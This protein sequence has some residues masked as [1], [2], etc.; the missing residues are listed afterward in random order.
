MLRILSII[1]KFF[2]CVKGLKLFLCVFYSRFGKF[3]EIQFDQSGRISGA[4][5]RTYL[6]E[7]SRVCQVSDP[8]RNYHCFYMLCAAPEEV[9]FRSKLTFK[10]TSEVAADSQRTK[11]YTYFYFQDAKKFKLGDPKIYHYLNQSKCI[12]L[13]AMND[14]EEYHATKKAMDV[15]GISSEEQVPPSV[16]HSKT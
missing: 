2:L 15:V 16:K 4:A 11:M 6:L 9:S 8:E 14:A 13:D 12:Q 10:M 7:R 5:I 3:V 1:F